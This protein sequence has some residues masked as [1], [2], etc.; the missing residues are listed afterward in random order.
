MFS[1]LQ[2]KP[3][4]R[5]NIEGMNKQLGI[6]EKCDIINEEVFRRESKFSSEMIR[7]RFYAFVTYE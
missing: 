7:I 3:T 5:N 4:P 6:S 1:Q 2:I